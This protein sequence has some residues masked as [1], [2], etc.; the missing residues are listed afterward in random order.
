MPSAA[1]RVVRVLPNHIFSDYFRG[2]I[3]SIFRGNFK[4]I[5]KAYFLIILEAILR[6]S[7]W[8]LRPYFG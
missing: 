3:K 4:A 2:N 1:E 5:F 8:L 6:N 7:G